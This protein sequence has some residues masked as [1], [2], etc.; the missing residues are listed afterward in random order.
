[1]VNGKGGQGKEQRGGDK[2]K[3]SY[4]YCGVSKERDSEWDLPGWS[5]EVGWCSEVGGLPS[6][7]FGKN[8]TLN[9]QA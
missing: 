9:T 4:G 6:K 7:A 8:W 2:T 5:S 3:V 1:M